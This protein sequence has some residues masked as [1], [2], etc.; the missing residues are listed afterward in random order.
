M[1]KFFGALGTGFLWLYLVVSLVCAGAVF[2]SMYD[3]VEIS[4]GWQIILGLIGF[5]WMIIGLVIAFVVVVCGAI[6]TLF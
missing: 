5:P 2:A 1:M 4:I 6:G 3:Y